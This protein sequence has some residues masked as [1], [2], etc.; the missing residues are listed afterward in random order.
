MAIQK[1]L[2]GS[3]LLDGVDNLIVLCGTC[4]GKRHGMKEV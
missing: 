1:A 2:G 4:H 3:A